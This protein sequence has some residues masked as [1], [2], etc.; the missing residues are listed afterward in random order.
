M[1][2]Y[3]KPTQTGS[4][5][6]QSDDSKCLAYGRQVKELLSASDAATWCDHLWE[7]Y[8]GYMLAQKEFGYNPQAVHVFYSFKDLF[9]F[10]QQMKEGPELVCE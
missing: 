6:T 1:Q 10:F 7:M 3:N 4:L 8:G 9:F 2:K 5:D